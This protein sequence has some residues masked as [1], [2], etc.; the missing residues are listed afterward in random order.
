MLCIDENIDIDIIQLNRIPVCNIKLFVN[1]S[2][3]MHV[4]YKCYQY[5][6][7]YFYHS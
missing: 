3:K 4:L 7:T 2:I 6:M 1:G 5:L